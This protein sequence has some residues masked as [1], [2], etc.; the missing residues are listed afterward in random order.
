MD[1]CLH[2]LLSMRPLL[3][4]KLLDNHV[5]L[6]DVRLTILQMEQIKFSLLVH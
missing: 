3:H 5:E 6:F 4:V 2:E 1:L